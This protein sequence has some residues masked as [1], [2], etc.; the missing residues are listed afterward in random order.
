M[1]EINYSDSGEKAVSLGFMPLFSLDVDLNLN[2]QCLQSQ[3]CKQMSRG[4]MEQQNSF[5]FMDQNP[6]ILPDQK[7]FSFKY[8]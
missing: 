1:Q 5:L 7:I 4:H 2:M 3:D 8:F 6:K